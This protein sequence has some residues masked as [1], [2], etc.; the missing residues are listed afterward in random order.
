MVCYMDER[1]SALQLNIDFFDAA[2]VWRLAPQHLNISTHRR[3]S[4]VYRWASAVQL[5]VMPQV[6]WLAP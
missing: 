5:V 6:V 1:S 3:Q 2:L 4:V